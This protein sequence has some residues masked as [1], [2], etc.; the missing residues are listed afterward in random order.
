VSIRDAR[1]DGGHEPS[2]PERTTIQ[3]KAARTVFRVRYAETDQMGMA[4]YANYLVWFEVM[5]GDFMRAVGAP[6]TRLEQEGTLLPVI[7]AG[8]RYLAPARYDDVIEVSAWIVELRSRR[9]AFAYRVERDGQALATGR[10]VHLPMGRDGRPRPFSR[11]LR[12][13]LEG[14]LVQE[15]EGA[16]PDGDASKPPR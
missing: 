9:I 14:F 2:W 3:D 5:R 15:G 1:P 8:V 11:E 6:Y 16:D 4:Y 10:T 12:E 7:E 13:I